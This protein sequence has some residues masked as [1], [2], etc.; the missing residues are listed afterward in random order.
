[1]LGRSRG[2]GVN[3]GDTAYNFEQNIEANPPAIDI[4]RAPPIQYELER[5]SWH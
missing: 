3:R 1:M 4:G 5:S 2:I